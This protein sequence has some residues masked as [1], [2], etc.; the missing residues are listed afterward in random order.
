MRKFCLKRWALL[1]FTMCTEYI[2]HIN[3]IEILPLDQFWAIWMLLLKQILPILNGELKSSFRHYGELKMKL[4]IAMH[5]L[6]TSSALKP[7]HTRKW[8]SWIENSF[9]VGHFFRCCMFALL[10][11]LKFKYQNRFPF[12]GMQCMLCWLAS[13]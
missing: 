5:N 9:N 13:V 11:S 1:H 10:I 7:T 12:S 8:Y 4:F 2:L 3:S 6:T